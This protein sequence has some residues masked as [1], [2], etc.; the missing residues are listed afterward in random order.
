VAA[1]LA[2][3]GFL[4]AL[5]LAGGAR[6][7]RAV[8]YDCSDFA[9]QAEAQ[10][11]LLPGDPYALD[12]DGDGIACESLPCPCSSATGGGGQQPAPAPPPP[13]PLGERTTA[14]VIRAVDGDT[15]DVRLETG[16]E[17]D[18]RL[19]GI[20]TPETHRPGTPIECGGPRASRSM[21]R[22][23]DRRR[24]TL[25]SDPTQDRFDRYGRLLAYAIRGR[26]DLNRAQVRGGWAKVYVYAGVPFERVATYRRAA[27]GARSEG[28]GVWRRCG[29]DFHSAA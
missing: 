3:I 10:N 11:Q 15:L 21:H 12:G 24:V 28:R 25:V 8:D 4:A 5:G 13:A 16:E 7:A 19:I 20:D 18:V 14:L 22:M 27:A 6:P 26:V 23:A 2:L 29:G 9:N 17:I 1:T